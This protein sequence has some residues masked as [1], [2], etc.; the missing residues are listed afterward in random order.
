M[1]KMKTTLLVCLT[2]L[3]CMLMLAACGDNKQPTQDA[4]PSGNHGETSD[5][6]ST[7]HVHDFGEWTVIKEASCTDNGTKERSCPCGQTETQTIAAI[8]HTEVIDPAKAPTCTEN[9][10]TEGTHCSVC[11]MVISNQESIPMLDHDLETHPANPATCDT[12]GWAEYVTCKRVD[13]GYTTYELIPAGHTEVVDTAVEPT[14]TE[15]GLTQGKHCSVCNH[16]IVKQEYLEAL[17]HNEVIDKAVAATCTTAGLTEGAHCERCHT[18]FVQQEVIA[19]KDHTLVTDYGYDATC[20]SSGLTN[21]E[22]CS[23]CKKTITAQKTIPMLGHSYGMKTNSCERCAKKEYPEIKS[24]NE[25]S[26]YDGRSNVVIFLDKCITTSNTSEA[27]IKTIYTDATYVKFIGTAGVTYN[28]CIV[29]DSS[30]K[31]ELK[32]DFVDVTLKAINNTPVINSKCSQDI[33]L[34]FY[35][36]TCQLLAKNG[37]NGSSGFG[38]LSISGED[39]TSGV[40]AIQAKGTVNITVAANKVNIYGGNGGAGGNGI[41]AYGPFDGGDGGNGGN[42]AYAI[43]A[44]SIHIY[45][46]NGHASNEI[47]MKGGT[48]G[49]GGSG[50][51]G[52]LWTDDGRNGSTGKSM[53]ATTVTPTYH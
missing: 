52:F 30:R 37:T 14:C 45:G 9:G 33:S 3:A 43:S 31:T 39:G 49:K 44:S 16:I 27:W 5:E 35:G 17:G 34:G 18:V 38:D 25:L 40:N 21:G 29:V 19:K 7:S 53:P 28:L 46:S 36:N 47:V 11:G 48:G 41:S 12:N 42:G 1:Q 23:S 6:A 51:N 10:L 22:H 50:G 20:T 4:N 24:R 13:C 2:M 32:I 8:A 15:S 26:S